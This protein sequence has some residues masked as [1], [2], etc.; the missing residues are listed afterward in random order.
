MFT[1]DVENASDGEDGDR[2]S[3]HFEFVDI[4]RQNDQRR[5][6]FVRQLSAPNNTGSCRVLP[7]LLHGPIGGKARLWEVEEEKKI[8]GGKRLF[9][10]FSFGVKQ[11][12]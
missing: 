1:R 7:L 3:F 10:Q 2:V 5:R 8:L 11:Q 9:L 6:Q 12:E 4:F